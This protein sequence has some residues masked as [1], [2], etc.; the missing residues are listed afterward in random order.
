[1]L[2][3]NRLYWFAN[4]IKND[5]N[6]D[7]LDKLEE[8]IKYLKLYYNVESNEIST[9][10]QILYDEYDKE[11][12]I[13]S[14]TD[15]DNLIKSKKIIEL[16]DY[17]KKCTCKYYKDDIKKIEKECEFQDP[18]QNFKSAEDDSDIFEHL[19]KRIAYHHPLQQLK[20]I[21][22]DDLTHYEFYERFK[23]DKHINLFIYKKRSGYNNP[24]SDYWDD[25][26]YIN[27][28][29]YMKK[30]KFELLLKKI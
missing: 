14:L 26:D 20:G 3:V 11:T 1:M 21:D 7:K 9:L 24:F 12:L 18:K 5:C 15:I 4:T 16:S 23:N 27:S 29:A 10:S 28:W 22:G 13:E 17:N 8:N 6:Y 19:L 30:G 2:D 25:D